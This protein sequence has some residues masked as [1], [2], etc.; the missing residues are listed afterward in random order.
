MKIVL[1]QQAET[2]MPWQARYDAA[3]FERAI[4]E[5]RG[6]GI[7]PTE[8]RRSD[9]S[10]WRVYTGTSR[11]SRETAALLFTHPEPPT[12]TALLDDVPLRA[13]QDTGRAR[14]LWLWRAMAA[15]RWAAGDAGQMETRRETVKRV[16]QFA[17]LVERDG[18]D[19]VVIS[20]G[21][22]M[23]AL[24]QVLR[25]RGYCLEGGDLLPKP[26]ERV[27]ASKNS[28]H[29][30]GCAHNCLLSEAKCQTGKNKALGI[31]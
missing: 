7:V 30:G 4:A 20:R 16:S 31:R 11:A 14:P 3:G 13:F 21:L 19:C 10:G 25:R 8:Q 17:D 9:A 18:R 24:K 28:L 26:L 2:D 12:E 1:I 29:C 27:R 15:A 22:T 5:E 23:R 6:R